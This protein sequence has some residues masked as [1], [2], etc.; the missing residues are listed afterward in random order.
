MS[1]KKTRIITKLRLQDLKNEY[2]RLTNND[3]LS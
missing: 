2:L 1:E 3:R